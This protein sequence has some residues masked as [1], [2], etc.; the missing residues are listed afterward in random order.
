MHHLPFREAC[1]PSC[2]CV[3]LSGFTS[4]QR[5]YQ[6]CCNPLIAL[7]LTFAQICTDWVCCSLF[8]HFFIAPFIETVSFSQNLQA[9]PKGGLLGSPALMDECLVSERQGVQKASLPFTTGDSL[10]SHPHIPSQHEHEVA[11]TSRLKCPHNTTCKE[12]PW[13][14]MV[15]YLLYTAKEK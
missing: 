4:S 1:Q 9:F 11:M 5:V 6:I 10:F 14:T 7:K 2:P 12:E 15:V 13:G 8:S 3:I